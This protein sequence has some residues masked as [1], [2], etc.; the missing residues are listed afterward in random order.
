MVLKIN[1]KRRRAA[2][3]RSSK[4][5]LNEP[6]QSRNDLREKKSSTSVRTKN[7][8]LVLKNSS[9]RGDKT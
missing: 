9:V 6:K 8:D 2:H 4:V 3:E 1:A 7:Y 5:Y